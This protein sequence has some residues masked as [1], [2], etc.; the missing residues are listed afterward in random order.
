MECDDSAEVDDKQ[1]LIPIAEGSCEMEVIMIAHTL[2]KFGATVLLA[3]MDKK[4]ECAMLCG[5]L[6]QADITIQQAQDY[7]WDLVILPGG[8]RGA[9][10]MRESNDL[11]RLLHR[12][13]DEHK[14]YAASG[15]AP[16]VVLSDTGLLP[17]VHTTYPINRLINKM[18]DCKDHDVIVSGN[19]VITQG[20]SKVF[21]F[22]MEVGELL[23]GQKAADLVC[24]K[25]LFDRT[26]I[27]KPKVVIIPKKEA[28]LVASDYVPSPSQPCEELNEANHSPED[29][30]GEL[31]NGKKLSS[32][33]KYNL[34]MLK[35][36]RTPAI[37]LPRLKMKHF[38]KKR[39]SRQE[40][41]S[42]DDSSEN[43][44]VKTYLPKKKQAVESH[45]DYSDRPQLD[46]VKQ[47]TNPNNTRMKRPPG[48]PKHP[49]GAKFAWCNSKRGL[50]SRQNPGFSILEINKKMADMWDKTT[51]QE[52]K[53][54]EDAEIIDWKKFKAELVA[55]GEKNSA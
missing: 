11:L 19:C 12:Q 10:A 24:R 34:A 43:A 14:L 20:A 23:Y 15:A 50:V 31:Q 9:M 26:G 54:Y 44:N 18:P 3:S 7:D 35:K 49:L 53:K 47:L 28:K 8:E 33:R 37:Q 39:A 5:F 46:I 2:K 25:L 42:N 55:Y 21:P 41:E 48:Y 1:V 36:Y 27:L 16:A 45:N 22:A 4:R 52:R 32:N 13:R 51:C 29:G 6:L 40:V 30:T 38:R 17:A